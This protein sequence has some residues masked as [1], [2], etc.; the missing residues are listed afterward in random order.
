MPVGD[1]DVL[2]GVLMEKILLMLDLEALLA[3]ASTCK[4]FCSL[5][6]GRG[7]EC[8]RLD[9]AK[10]KASKL[11]SEPFNLSKRDVLRLTELELIGRPMGRP[12]GAKGASVL[13]QALLVGALPKLEQLRLGFNQIGDEGCKTLAEHLPTSMEMLSLYNN[14]IG[15]EG[16]KAL[17]EHLPTSLETLS[18][19]GNQIGDEGCKALAEHLTTTCTS[20]KT[21]D[22]G[23][24]QI[25]DEGCKVL[26][27][28]LP[29]SLT[30]LF[31]GG[32]RIGD[33]GCKALADHLPTTCTSLKTLDLG[34][35]QIGDEGCKVLA[36]HLP[37][38]LQFLMMALE[39]STLSAAC[40]ERGVT[41]V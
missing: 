26:A 18:L 24:N 28:H 6:I 16:C 13:S 11:F 33:E 9:E 17:A 22:L 41:F 15:D 12:L 32:N 8:L 5:L 21:L 14:Q 38:S 27:E 31:L 34:M 36:E 35:N 3:A 7:G 40:G 2:P 10:T 25:G 23:M 29:T 19:T 20:L 39:H 30:Q 4:G 37:T 1:L